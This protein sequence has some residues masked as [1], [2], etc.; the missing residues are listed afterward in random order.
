[1]ADPD[2][3]PLAASDGCPGSDPVEVPDREAPDGRAGG[4]AHEHPVRRRVLR[5]DEPRPPGETEPLPLPHGEEPVP[6]VA[7]DLAPGHFVHHRARVLAEVGGDEVAVADAAEKA[8]PLAVPTILRGQAEPGGDPADIR[9][10]ETAHREER[11]L[12]L[13][14]ADPREEIGLVLHRIRSPVE[15]GPL[16]SADPKRVVPGGQPLEAAARKLGVQPVGKGPELDPGVTEE[17]RTRG[18]AA[19]ELVQQVGDHPLAVGP[20]QGEDGEGNAELSGDRADEAEILLP[21]AAAQMFQLVLEPDFQVESVDLMP[22]FDEAG[23][24]DGAVHPPRG[25]QSDAHGSDQSGNHRAP[26]GVSVSSSSAVGFGALR[27]SYPFMTVPPSDPS[28]LRQGSLLAIWTKSGRAEPMIPRNE[29]ELV[30][31]EGLSGSAPA[32]GKR[33]VTVLSQEAW[34]QAAAE[35]GHPD[36]DPMLRRANLLV[37]GVDL[38]E[39]RGRTLAV[40]ETRILIHGETKPCERMDAAAGSLREAL[41]PDWRAGVFGEVLCGGPIRVGDP[42]GWMAP[43]PVMPDPVM[44]DPVS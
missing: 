29:G 1:M 6:A 26:R 19:F 24:G 15:L 12:E 42:V 17:I 41:G 18:A 37:R 23:E 2:Q 13:G 8:D 27:E 36:A 25:E 34:S 22:R 11:A 32:R 21:G 16:G 31:G 14:G 40:G 9:L 43:D 44:P 38:R 39:T 4:T 28:G 5:R 7:P 33:Q 30:C 10:L 3:Q 35:A 20:L